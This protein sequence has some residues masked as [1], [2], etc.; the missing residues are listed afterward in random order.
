MQDAAPQ[1]GPLMTRSIAWGQICKVGLSPS[2]AIRVVAA[3]W[4]GA[5]PGIGG[6]INN[7]KLKP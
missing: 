7:G 2:A 6:R 4:G 1:F 5:V 3:A